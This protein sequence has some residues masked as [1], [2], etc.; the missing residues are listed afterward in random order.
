[1][2]FFSGTDFVIV[3]KEKK[4]IDQNRI[5]FE[6]IDTLSYFNKLSL[7]IT[8]HREIFAPVLLSLLSPS[9]VGKF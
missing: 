4:M 7:L 3:T 8:V 1:M 5:A 2:N 6:K 9:S